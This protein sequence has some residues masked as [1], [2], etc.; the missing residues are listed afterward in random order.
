M[1]K[2]HAH[3]GLFVRQSLTVDPLGLRGDLTSL[4]VTSLQT[5][6][7]CISKMAAG[8]ILQSGLCNTDVYC[9]RVTLVSQPKWQQFE[10]VPSTLCMY[11]PEAIGCISQC[12][13][14]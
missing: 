7:R 2:T 3:T 8:I 11:E 9:F 14:K 13:F 5:S 12:N 6:S 1:K 4:L 10:Q